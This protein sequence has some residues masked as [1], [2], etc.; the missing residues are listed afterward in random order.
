MTRRRAWGTAILAA[1]TF[2]AAAPATAEPSSAPAGMGRVL[3]G[4]IDAGEFHTC[5]VLDDGSLRCW[6]LG[7]HGQLGYGNQNAIGDQTGET[8]DGVGPV[9]L[10]AG[11]SAAELSAGDEHTCAVLDDGTVRCWGNGEFGALG[12]GNEDDIGESESPGSA[13]PVD[14]GAGRTATAIASGGG[15]TCAV[16]DDGAV[17]CWG[18]NEF[19]QLGYGNETRIGDDA[20]ETP[21][22]VGP[23]DLGAGRTATAI[24]AGEI[25]TCA[26]LDDG[27]ARCWGAGAV[28]QLGYGSPDDIGDT[29]TP[30]AAGPVEFGFGRF[31]TAITAGGRHTCALL[32]DA[33]VRCWGLGG[34]GRLG[35][36][37][38]D[39]F[40]DDPGE[41][42]GALGPV[43]LGPGRTATAITAGLRH[44]CALLDNGTVRCWGDGAFGQLGYGNPDDIGNDAGE[45]PGTVDPVDLGAARRG[46]A[47]T[48]GG[49]HTCALL[50]SGRIRCW[51]DGAFGAL[52]YGAEDDIGDTETPA[53][54]GPVEAGGLVSVAPGAPV[55]PTARL[56][57]PA[58]I[59]VVWGEPDSGSA[60]PLQYRVTSSAALPPVVTSATTATFTGL[61]DG[62]YTFSVTARNGARAGP[63]A[64]TNP[65][66]VVGSPPPPPPGAGD[67][68][69]AL[70]PVRVLDTRTGLGAAG[71]LAA[72]ATLA[73]SVPGVP[74][75]ATAVM[76][77]VTVTEPDRDGFLTVWPCGPA[78][79]LVSNLNF[80]AGESRP[81]LVVA[82]RGA[83]GQ[84]CLG[85]N[86]TTHVLADLAGWYAPIDATNS[87]YNPLA[88]QRLVDTRVSGV[89]VTF[90]APLAVA[91]V[92]GPVPAD[93]SAVM[94]NVTA[95]DAADDG[96]LTVWPCDEP[97]PVVSNVNYTAGQIVPNAVGVKT[98]PTGTVCVATFATTDVVVDRVGWFGPTGDVYAPLDPVRV[99]DTR[100]AL[101]APRGKQAA[102][103]I[104]SLTVPGLPTDASG[105]IVNVTATEPDGDGFVTVWPCGQPRPLAST[106]NVTAGQLAAPNLAA[107]ALGP[108]QQI[109][110]SGNTTT[111][112]V[113]DLNG[114]YHP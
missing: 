90:T 21:G 79:P 6:G 78:R 76:V 99:L 83:A 101:G 22:T 95:V 48:A 17:R 11:R 2:V 87:R 103:T 102:E 33:T 12:Y 109:C 15:H 98:S 67:G 61:A 18:S 52:G 55:N 97:Q 31:A 51:G 86:A 89:P 104:L 111:H 3:A 64:T 30:A 40:G 23:V 8:P 24:A 35:Y 91:V 37:N 42:P 9:D 108:G 7:I 43:E 71:P 56:T 74:V 107:V 47:I 41:T 54:V 19:G 94:L 66:V 110:L 32:D 13:G 112:L 93:T 88:P 81:N 50:D 63:P 58:E 75:E 59:T 45:T 60:P 5:A 10:G 57:G 16:L 100:T 105:V 69:V 77:N 36:G 73:L 38:T 44:V 29:E 14:L 68:F 20:G 39:N 113:A 72:E 106:L 25:H 27:T 85:G 70:S 62:T 96:F 53:T 80:A 26:L 28:G 4:R 114:S 82:T 65:I 46:T 84:I 92:G 1:A 49:N 34:D